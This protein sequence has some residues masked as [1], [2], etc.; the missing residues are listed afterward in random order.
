[1]VEAFEIERERERDREGMKEDLE[2]RKKGGKGKK[3][4]RLGFFRRKIGR[5]KKGRERSREGKIG[6]GDERE[7]RQE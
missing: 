1:M 3:E 7:G 2:R 4:D 5:R 6:E